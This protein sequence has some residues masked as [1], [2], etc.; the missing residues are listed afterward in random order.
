[1]SYSVFFPVLSLLLMIGNYDNVGFLVYG[2][3]DEY[4][5]DDFPAEF[6]FGSATSAY[7]VF[8]LIM[9]FVISSVCNIA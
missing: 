1:M 4:R 2:V 9:F 8:A 7:Q 3:V 5:R 6:V